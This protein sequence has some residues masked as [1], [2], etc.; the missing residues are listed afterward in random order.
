MTTTLTTDDDDEDRL[1][2]LMNFLMMLRAY[3]SGL[4]SDSQVD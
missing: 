3:S 4:E 1:P 2:L